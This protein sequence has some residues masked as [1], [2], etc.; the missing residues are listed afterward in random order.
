MV[1]FCQKHPNMLAKVFCCCCVFEY[2]D[3]P[4]YS[5]LQLKLQ[6]GFQW[7]TR[8]ITKNLKN[9][10]SDGHSAI[11]RPLYNSNLAKESV[12]LGISILSLEL[13][14]LVYPNYGKTSVFH[15]FGYVRN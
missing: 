6:W 5:D 12:G 2:T 13:M 10:L 11:L 14:F 8:Q 3:Q 4:S 9:T 15:T 1:N 7:E